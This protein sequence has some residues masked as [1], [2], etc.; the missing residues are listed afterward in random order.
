MYIQDALKETGMAFRTGSKLYVK[1]S[2]ERSELVW[3][4]RNDNAPCGAVIASRPIL[5]DDWLPYYS[6]LQIAPKEVG[7]IWTHEDA[8]YAVGVDP[9]CDFVMLLLFRHTNKPPILF[10]ENSQIIHNKDGWVRTHPPVE[11]ENV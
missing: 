6:E 7:E 2:L 10:I 1:Y 9:Q 4:R 5:Q 3:Q 8:M 11:V